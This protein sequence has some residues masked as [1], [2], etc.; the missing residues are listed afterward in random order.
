MSGAWKGGASGAGAPRPVT[1]GSLVDL[2]Y[3]RYVLTGGVV[4]DLADA[5]DDGVALPVGARLAVI[6]CE[7]QAIRWV[8][9]ADAGSILSATKGMPLATGIQFTYS[10][11]LAGLRF[12][13]Q[14]SGAVL[15]VSYFK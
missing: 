15:H 4:K 14:S 13:E 6:V 2:G 9:N 3:A 1:E 12:I 5:P 10:G 7:T 8:N 11:D